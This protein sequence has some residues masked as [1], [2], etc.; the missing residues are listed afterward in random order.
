[1]IQELLG[2]TNFAGRDGFYWW[3]GQ[4][5]TEKGG[6]VKTNDDR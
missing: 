1:M 5:E 4:I 3:M 6:Q 2:Q